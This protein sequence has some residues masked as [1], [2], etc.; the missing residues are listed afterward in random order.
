MV[1]ARQ[2]RPSK[3]HLLK[4][5]TEEQQRISFFPFLF[6]FFLFWSLRCSLLAHTC[7][8]YHLVDIVFPPSHPHSKPSFPR[9]PRKR[10]GKTGNQVRWG[11]STQ[12][13]DSKSPSAQLRKASSK[14]ALK[15]KKKTPLVFG[16]LE[17]RFE[18]G[19]AG[20]AIR[21]VR[22]DRRLHVTRSKLHAAC[23]LAQCSPQLYSL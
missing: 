6:P 22:E 12:Q 15:K 7:T 13:F 8:S 4:L 2:S 16:L 20:P 11:F 14:K 10:R 18:K 23:F 3:K 9:G 19:G 17:G 21:H 5:S 1:R